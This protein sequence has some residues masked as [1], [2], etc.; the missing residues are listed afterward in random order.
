[1]ADFD[2][3]R[4]VECLPFK[5]NPGDTPLEKEHQAKVIDLIYSNQEVFSCMMKTWVTMTD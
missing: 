3:K 4:Q 5:V 2:F 1:M